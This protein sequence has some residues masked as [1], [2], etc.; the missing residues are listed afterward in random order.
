MLR[1][2]RFSALREP[3]SAVSKRMLEDVVLSWLWLSE[4]NGPPYGILAASRRPQEGMWWFHRSL[5]KGTFSITIDML[6]PPFAHLGV[7]SLR[8]QR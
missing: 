4:G 6:R 1:T 7:D 3:I 8:D 2:T 5:S